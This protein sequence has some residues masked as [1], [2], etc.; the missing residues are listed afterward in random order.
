MNCPESCWG[1]LRGLGGRAQQQ[2]E[3]AGVGEL[4]WAR[5]TPWRCLERKW[6][7]EEGW[8]EEGSCDSVF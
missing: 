7:Y 3:S 8:E 2:R 5:P 4:C 1:S 6:G